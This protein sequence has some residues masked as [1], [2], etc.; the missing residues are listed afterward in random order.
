MIVKLINIWGFNRLR[1]FSKCTLIVI[2]SIA[3][4]SYVTSYVLF[5]TGANV[6][7]ISSKIC[8]AIYNSLSNI[9]L[10]SI[11]VFKFTCL[12]NILTDLAA[13][14]IT[15]STFRFFGVVVINF[16]SYQIVLKG[17]SFTP[18]N[19]GWLLPQNNFVFLI[20]RKKYLR[21]I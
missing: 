3:K 18:A 10:V 17:A 6:K 12:L 19:Q 1:Y 8:V 14:I 13:F 2:K 7:F 11:S 9:V 20:R 15:S 4:T 5:T 16:C 21:L